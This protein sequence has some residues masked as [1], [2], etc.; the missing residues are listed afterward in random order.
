MSESQ[1]PEPVSR[2]LY[3][4]LPYLTE[5]PF[6]DT[7]KAR[8]FDPGR[9]SSVIQENSTYSYLKRGTLSQ[10]KSESQRDVATEEW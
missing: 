3:N 7:I 9:L 6:A 2:L 8:D 10:L 5:M 1:S 4:S